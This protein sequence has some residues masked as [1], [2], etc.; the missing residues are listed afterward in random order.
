MARGKAVSVYL[1]PYLV[2]VLES[3]VLSRSKRV[4]KNTVSIP[5]DLTVS[6]LV[7]ACVRYVVD[8]GKL[9]FVYP[10]RPR[11]PDFSGVCWTKLGRSHRH[12]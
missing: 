10:K 8:E 6:R 7:A 3:E 4:R 12:R 9:Q 5:K 11:L 2:S 1:E